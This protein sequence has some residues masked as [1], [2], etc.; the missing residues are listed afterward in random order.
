MST[1]DA[2]S[3]AVAV[4]RLRTDQPDFE[5]EFA[6]LR[7]WS[8]DTDAAIEERVAAILAAPELLW[9]DTDKK[10]RPRQRDCRPALQAE[11]E[12]GG[13]HTSGPQIRQGWLARLRSPLSRPSSASHRRQDE[14]QADQE[15][16]DCHSNAVVLKVIEGGVGRGCERPAQS[17]FQCCGR[18]QNRAPVSADVGGPIGQQAAPAHHQIIRDQHLA[19]RCMR[20][21]SVPCLR[22]HAP[23]ALQSASTTQSSPSPSHHDGDSKRDLGRG[24]QGGSRSLGEQQTSSSCHQISV[25][26]RLPLRRRCR[27]RSKPKPIPPR[28]R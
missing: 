3:R 2:L 22:S 20:S 25:S 13:G 7:H 4:R 27:P 21:A 16:D 14:L 26:W 10:G 18:L 17:T 15:A 5:A 28:Q 23:Q 8:A 6:R 19:V 12:A 9:H 1:G 24:K 11:V